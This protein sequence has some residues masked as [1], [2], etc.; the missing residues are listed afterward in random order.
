MLAEDFRC[1]FQTSAGGTGLALPIAS[2]TIYFV[3]ATS[4]AP[5]LAVVERF[6]SCIRQRF[7]PCAT[8]PQF[9]HY[10]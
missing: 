2:S 3:F 10:C 5:P 4:V 9:L 7:E 8:S 1:P 6:H